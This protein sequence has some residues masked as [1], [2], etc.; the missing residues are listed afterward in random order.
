[1]DTSVDKNINLT[2][3]RRFTIELKLFKP[4]IKSARLRLTQHRKQAAAGVTQNSVPRVCHRFSL[5]QDGQC[6]VCQIPASENNTGVSLLLQGS[7]RFLKV[8]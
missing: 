6:G 4:E 5:R 2:K 3:T 8:C 7:A 1:M